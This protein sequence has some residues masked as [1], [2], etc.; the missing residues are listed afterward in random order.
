MSLK[1]LAIQMCQSF[2][3]NISHEKAFLTQS[4]EEHRKINNLC[5]DTA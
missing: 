1:H 3:E 4:F 5:M 2:Y